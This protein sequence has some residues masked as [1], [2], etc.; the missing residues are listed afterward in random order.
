MRASTR[1]ALDDL[2]AC[3]ALGDLHSERTI[4]HVH[5]VAAAA[6]LAQGD[7]GQSDIAFDRALLE[8]G[9]SGAA[10]VFRTLPEPLLDHLVARAVQREQP[11]VTQGV[12]ARLH[13]AEGPVVPP[14]AEPLSDRELV[15]VRHLATG[16]TLGQIGSQL[17]ISVNTVKSHV[18]S[19]Y[20]KLQASSRREAIARVRQLGL[21]VDED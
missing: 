20:R 14:L 18:R 8:A 12:L 19:I 17:F 5:A 15:I 21:H 16:Q 2:E 13:S 10:W 7:T 1:A 9:R 11:S 3:L 6:H 4:G